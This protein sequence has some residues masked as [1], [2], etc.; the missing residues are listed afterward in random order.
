MILYKR[1]DK[2]QSYDL[3]VSDAFPFI[4]SHYY[5]LWLQNNAMLAVKILNIRKG[6]VVRITTILCVVTAQ[7]HAVYVKMAFVIQL[8]TERAV[9]YNVVNVKK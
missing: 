7:H 3:R 9:V 5:I 8:G 1:L 2:N 6:M 4:R